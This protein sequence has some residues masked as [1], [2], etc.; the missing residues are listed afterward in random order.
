MDVSGHDG[1]AV[2]VNGTKVCVFEEFDKV[3]FGGFL[4]GEHCRTLEAKF[5][6][7]IFG[8]FAN[9][10]LEVELGDQ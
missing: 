7:V 9:K 4:E 6:T 2:C 10:I 5:Y 1:D 8:N 3:G